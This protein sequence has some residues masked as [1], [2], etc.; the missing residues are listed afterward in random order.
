[1]GYL[2]VEDTVPVLRES[3]A[4]QRGLSNRPETAQMIHY[5]CRKCS[6]EEM[7][8]H[9]SVYYDMTDLGLIFSG[10]DEVQGRLS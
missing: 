2:S 6:E 9:V 4:Q 10:E 7:Q 8:D 5:N 1:M 3:R